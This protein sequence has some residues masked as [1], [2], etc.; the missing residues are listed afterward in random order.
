MP[1]WPRFEQALTRYRDLEQQL[2]DPV[3]IGDR[4]RYTSVAKEHGALAKQ[5]KPYLDFKKLTDDLAEHEALLA[6]E[7]DPSMR[8]YLEEEIAKQ[9]ADHQALQTRLEDFL[10]LDP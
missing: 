3:V 1:M 5:V 6:A 4:A 2:A 8:A 10:L 7:T 9:K